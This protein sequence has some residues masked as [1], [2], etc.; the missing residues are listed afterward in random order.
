MI[1][2]VS[3]D[4]D[5]I[6]IADRDGQV[7]Y[8]GDGD[9]LSSFNVYWYWDEEDRVWLYNSDDGRVYFW[10][11]VGDKWKRQKWGYSR[12]REIERDISPPEEMYPDYEK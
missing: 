1:L 3:V 8:K 11:R 7:L 10:E 12:T 2:E 9:F 5:W 6:T 4:R